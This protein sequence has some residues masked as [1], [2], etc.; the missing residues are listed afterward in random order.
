M[1]INIVLGG[2]DIFVSSK[3][4]LLFVKFSPLSANILNDMN[5]CSNSVHWFLSVKRAII[6]F[7]MIICDF[8]YSYILS[9]MDD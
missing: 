4:V 9:Y 8:S 1:Y 5:E 7:K 2:L 3:C 6:P